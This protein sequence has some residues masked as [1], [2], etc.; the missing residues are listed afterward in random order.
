MMR[1][2]QGRK[3]KKES[4]PSARKPN[5]RRKLSEKKRRTRQKLLAER[6]RKPSNPQVKKRT[7]TAG[8]VIANPQKKG[9]RRRQTPAKSAHQIISLMRRAR[10]PAVANPES[11]P[12]VPSNF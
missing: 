12:T 11:T 10:T 3:S 2:Q 6:P 1:R 9:R 8:Q 7:R 4:K 5:T